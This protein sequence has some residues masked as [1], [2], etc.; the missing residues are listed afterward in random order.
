MPVLSEALTQA[1][2]TLTIKVPCST[3]KYKLKR[4]H[5]KKPVSCTIFSKIEEGIFANYVMALSSFGFPVD[6]DLRSIVK[7]YAD[8][9][10]MM[11]RQFTGSLIMNDII[12][13]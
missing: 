9:R 3:L 4:L 12:K 10:G 7:S 8:Q 2:G 11:D 5:I 13:G 1:N 6:Y